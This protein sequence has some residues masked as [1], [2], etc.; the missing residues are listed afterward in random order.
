MNGSSY[1]SSPWLLTTAFLFVCGCGGEKVVTQEQVPS[2]PATESPSA[3]TQSSTTDPPT[4]ATTGDAETSPS[5]THD[6]RTDAAPKAEPVQHYAFERCR[7]GA[8]E[9]VVK[10]AELRRYVGEGEDKKNAEGASRYFIVRLSVENFGNENMMIPPLKLVDSEGRSYDSSSESWRFSDGLQALE[11]LNPG[12]KKEYQ[13]AF[14][15]PKSFE[16]HGLIVSGGYYSSEKELILFERRPSTREQRV[17]PAGLLD[18]FLPAGPAAELPLEQAE[19]VPHDA[20]GPMPSVGQSFR[21]GNWLYTVKSVQ[22]ARTVGA[23]RTRAKNGVYLV[24][25]VL[26][27]PYQTSAL[28]RLDVTD[29]DGSIVSVADV[30]KKL[31]DFSSTSDFSDRYV[32]RPVVLAFDVRAGESYRLVVRGGSSLGSAEMKFD[33]AKYGSRQLGIEA[34]VLTA[35][36]EMVEPKGGVRAFRQWT[37]SDDKFRMWGVLSSRSG[38]TAQIIRESDGTKVTV[39]IGQLSES[40]RKY[41]QA[42]D[43]T[44]QTVLGGEIEIAKP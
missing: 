1:I 23:N 28:P 19:K 43:W 17:S 41:I 37:S 9:Y 40:D 5:A 24:L 30:S 21:V 11:R 3:L 8:F 7:V 6:E 33:L 4:D 14:E 31:S 44:R 12:I 34:N 22:W 16:S 36:R 26:C 39:P 32:V 10:G 18:V 20:T 35:E 42:G 13:L 2:L 27:Y 29:A 38:N 15:V 25:K